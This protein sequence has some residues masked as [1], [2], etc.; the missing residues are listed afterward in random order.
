MESVSEKFPRL[1]RLTKLDGTEV[2]K[3]CHKRAVGENSQD[4]QKGIKFLFAVVK[5]Q[6]KEDLP[7]I[8]LREVFVCF[9]QDNLLTS[10]FLRGDGVFLKLLLQ[11]V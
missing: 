2:N 10:Y 7:E 8:F 4:H 5:E 11:S 3:M 6:T 9:I 1:R